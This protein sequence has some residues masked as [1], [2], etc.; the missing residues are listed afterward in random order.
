MRE[1]LDISHLLG[2]PDPASAHAPEIDY[3]MALVHWL[4][5]VL[6]VGWGIYYIYVLLRF[7][8]SK[9]PVASYE[10]TKAKYSTYQES[11]VVVAEALLLVVFA[12]PIWGFLK[13]EF[14][15]AE[16]SVEVHVVAEQFAW[17]FHYPGDDGAFGRRDI[18]LIDLATNPLGLDMTDPAAQDD[19]VTVNE[20]H[21]PVNRP[22]IVRLTSKD[23]IHSFALPHMR[24]KQDA[25]PGLEIPLWFR[26]T[27]TGDYE[28]S[29]AQLCG[30]SHYRMRGYLTIHSQEDYE[31]WRAEALELQ[32]EFM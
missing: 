17:N 18:N 13:N 3:M 6:F 29:C 12:F 26:P 14:P 10:G 16:E 28:I 22:V 7:R 9:N 8:G 24:V 5:L 25:I 2:M 4:M 15:P 23:V 1:F 19:I 27:K 31:A 32:R 11:G 21:L 30:L 20:M